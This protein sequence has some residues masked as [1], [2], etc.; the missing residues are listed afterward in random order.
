MNKKRVV[1]LGI[2]V[3]T[4][5]CLT[6]AAPKNTGNTG[7]KKS[8]LR[9]TISLKKDEASKK[10]A[11]EDP[12]EE[13]YSYMEDKYNS[14][15]VDLTPE[16]KE[17]L[18]ETLDGDDAFPF[19]EDSKGTLYGFE[20]DLTYGCSAWCAVGDYKS[21]A[22][23]TSTLK[24][25]SGNKYDAENVMDRDRSDAWVEGVKGDGIGESISIYRTYTRGG[26]VDS[27]KVNNDRDVFF[28]P[29]ICIVN[30]LAKNQDAWAKNGRVKSLKMYFNDEYICTLELK[31]TPKPQYISLGGLGLSA[32]NGEESCF[33][34][35]IEKVYK[36]TKFD[37]TAITGIEIEM[38]TPSH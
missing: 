30:G 5:I 17:F 14:M 26:D 21:S 3:V 8:T 35:E 10:K 23:A 32:K 13:S 33:R 25:I 20:T 31:D 7:T 9:S 18:S 28:F 22:K 34:F 15:K 4:M 2:L 1:I 11:S 6:G 38:D 24:P 12:Y 36:G 37:D 19:K 16:V 29:N 27:S